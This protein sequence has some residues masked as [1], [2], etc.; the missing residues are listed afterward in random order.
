MIL[1]IL[2]SIIRSNASTHISSEDVDA[3]DLL[4]Y[5]K[6]C[7]PRSMIRFGDRSMIPVNPP[8]SRAAFVHWARSDVSDH[9]LDR[10]DTQKRSLGLL[11]GPAI[12]L[13]GH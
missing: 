8:L 1:Y 4:K 9:E 6:I 11:E 7:G 2:S 5:P 3:T 12:H 10:T 13:E